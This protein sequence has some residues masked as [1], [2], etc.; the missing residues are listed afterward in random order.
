MVKMIKMVKMV[1]KGMVAT[2][3]GPAQRN[4]QVKNRKNKNRYGSDGAWVFAARA[5]RLA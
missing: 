3:P 1:K 5:P 2:A 4:G